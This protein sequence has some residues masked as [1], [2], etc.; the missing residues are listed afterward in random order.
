M[1]VKSVLYARRV[2]ISPRARRYA[3]RVGALWWGGG[4]V[5]VGAVAG[6]INRL[7]TPLPEFTVYESPETVRTGNTVRY[8]RNSVP[9]R[10]GHGGYLEEIFFGRSYFFARV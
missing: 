5:V 6:A 7:P 3:L 1:H 2:R 4:S 10:V 8:H 9:R